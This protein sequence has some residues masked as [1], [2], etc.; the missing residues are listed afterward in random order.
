[1]YNL[2]KCL[3]N[4][5]EIRM[6]KFAAF[7]F[8]GALIVL[9][10]RIG[11]AKSLNEWLIKPGGSPPVISHWFASE[12]LHHGHDWKIYVEADDPDGDMRGFVAIL[13]QIG[14]GTYSSS[15][16][17]IKERHREE[18]R[19]YLVFSSST[20]MGPWLSEWTQLSLT[21]F[22][23]DGGGNKSNKVV[24]PL[25]LCRGAK[26]GSPPPPFDSGRL[27]KLGAVW[28]DL[29]EPELDGDDYEPL[30]P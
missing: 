25:V 7:V 13:D 8:I 29:V 18:L 19:G 30:P 3:T 11:Y 4:E 27:D 10:M 23:R 26:Q 28:F 5:K 16:V 15:Y 24:F 17:R 2:M 21:V 12:E 20:G 14:Y 6:K 22:I 9:P 1:M